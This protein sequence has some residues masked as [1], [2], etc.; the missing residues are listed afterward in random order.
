M[1]R[2]RDD[3]RYFYDALKFASSK[4]QKAVARAY[5]GE[6]RLAVELLKDASS[7]NPGDRGFIYYQ[8]ALVTESPAYFHL[9]LDAYKLAEDSRGVADSLVSL[10]RIEFANNRISKAQTYARR[11]VRVLESAGDSGRARTVE[12]WLSTL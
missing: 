6:T 7:Y 11:A 2:S 5:L 1:G 10:A 12:D 4:L 8:H 9:S 3:E